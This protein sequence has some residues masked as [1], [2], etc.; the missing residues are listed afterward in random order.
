MKFLRQWGDR[1]RIALSPRSPVTIFH[2]LPKCGGTSIN[3]M[4]NKWFVVQRDYRNGWEPDYPQ[5]VDVTQLRSCQ[6]LS[7][8]FELDGNHLHQRYPA[9]LRSDR[10][11]IF[12]FVRDPLQ[13]RLSLYRY[14][15]KSK[16]GEVPELE[17]HVLSHSNYISRRLPATMENYKEVLS[18]YFFIGIVEEMPTSLEKLAALLGKRTSE[19]PWENR[20]SDDPSFATEVPSALIEKFKAENGLDYAI[21]QHC[22]ERFRNDRRRHFDP[23]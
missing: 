17:Q 10:F 7:G 19:V 15:K 8:H 9:V 6:C 13:V 14:E 3:A 18:R 22:L 5:K 21:Y 1:L 11:R 12:T 4:L 23:P 20:T 16:E 2:H